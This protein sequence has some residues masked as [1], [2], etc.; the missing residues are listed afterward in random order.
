MPKISVIVP[1]YN[2]EKYLHRC[3]DSII[4]QTYKDIEIILV[5]DGST[6]RGGEICD[7]YAKLDNRIKVIHKKNGGLSDARNIGIE[8]STGEYISFVDSDDYIHYDMIKRL[9]INIKECKANISICGYLET[10]ENID[11]INENELIINNIKYFNNIEALNLLYDKKMGVNFVVSWGKLYEKNLFENILFPKAKLHEDQFTTYKLFFE[12]KKIVY[13]SSKLYFYFQRNDSIM[14]KQFNIKRMDIFDA[15][16][17]QLNLFE[18]YELNEL[19]KLAIEKYI[20]HIFWYID[21]IKGLNDKK[22]IKKQLKIKR[23]KILKIIKK[24][25]YMSREKIQFLG[26]PWFNPK[27]LELYWFY[28]AIYNKVKIKIE[29]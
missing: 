29:Y 11:V 15:Y 12:S 7:N 1:V 25:K 26:A 28:I 8:N 3:V 13:D 24:K 14:N 21:L 10:Y 18:K 23:N 27:Y 6:D 17:E 20:N 5:D 22:Y 2:V 9:Y 4:N 16:I 19:A